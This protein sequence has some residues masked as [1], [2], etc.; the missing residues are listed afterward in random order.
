MNQNSARVDVPAD[1][2]AASQNGR[3]RELEDAL[4]KDQTDSAVM[5]ELSRLYQENGEQRKAQEYRQMAYNQEDDD[6]PEFRDNRKA[7]QEKM[8]S[9]KTR[10]VDKKLIMLLNKCTKIR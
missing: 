10:P 5:L 4:V 3:I 7:H 8:E 6:F 1:L 9:F 2:S